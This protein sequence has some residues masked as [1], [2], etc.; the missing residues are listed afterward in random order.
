MAYASAQSMMSRFGEP[1]MIAL[2]DRTGADAVDDAVLGQALADSGTLI[3]GY[4]ASR[5]TLPL[6]VIPGMLEL[7]AC[8]IARYKLAERPTEEMRKRFDDAIGW[9]E[10][11][12][13]GK[14]GL[15]V[16]QAG[17]EPPEAGGAVG[18]VF[19]SR[20]RVFSADS[21]GD[22]APGGGRFG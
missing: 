15:G 6:A 7:L 19:T 2:T 9:L 1:E 10:K 4:L 21:L 3:D 17:Q 20:G 22:Y 16:D 12:A 5:Y 18:V 11:V 14:I 8:D 13:A